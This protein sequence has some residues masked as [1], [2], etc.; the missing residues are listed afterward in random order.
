M[1]D[2]KSVGGWREMPH[3][4]N[5]LSPG[6]ARFNGNTW[7]SL[8]STCYPERER[9]T[10]AGPDRFGASETNGGNAVHSAR[11]WTTP[12]AGSAVRTA[13]SRAIMDRAT[14]IPCYDFDFKNS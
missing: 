10:L 6:Q 8:H 7:L 5:A 2:A 3:D 12:S 14:T 4:A 1:R 11:R 13:H 9:L